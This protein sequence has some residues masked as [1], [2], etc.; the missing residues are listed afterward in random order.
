MIQC[1]NKEKGEAGEFKS[2]VIVGF[3]VL[4]RMEDK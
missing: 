1:L 3:H 2:M 4:D